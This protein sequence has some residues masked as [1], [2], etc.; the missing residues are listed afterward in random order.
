M[1]ASVDASISMKLEPTLWEPWNWRLHLLLEN[2]SGI[3]YG[4]VVPMVCRLNSF[5]KKS[6]VISSDTVDQA[7]TLRLV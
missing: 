3:A 7:V 1:H 6:R 4:L 2:I 5:E